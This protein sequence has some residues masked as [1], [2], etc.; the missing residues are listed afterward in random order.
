AARCWPPWAAWASCPGL[1]H[2]L[3]RYRPRDPMPGGYRVTVVSVSGCHRSHPP[4]IRGVHLDAPF[5][6]PARA[7]RRPCADRQRRMQSL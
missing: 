5:F 7:R 6:V 2:S 4:A 3:S 1:A